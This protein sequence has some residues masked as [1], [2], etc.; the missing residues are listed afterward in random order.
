M[1]FEKFKDVGQGPT[2]A[3]GA[4]ALAAALEDLGLVENIPAVL[5]T[6]DLLEGYNKPSRQAYA[7]RIYQVTGNLMLTDEI[8]LYQVDAPARH[9]SPPS[10]LTSMAHRC[11]IDTSNIRTFYNEA[12]KEHFSRLELVSKNPSLPNLFA[13]EFELISRQSISVMED[14]YSKFPDKGQVHL[15]GVNNNRH[16][17][18]I[19]YD[20]CYDSACGSVSFYNRVGQLPLTTTF[21]TELQ[22]YQFSGWWISLQRN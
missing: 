12:A 7:Q 8:A 18:A 22:E 19:N 1:S 20:T 9:Q 11:G 10:A 21:R 15:L 3:C 16:W 14:K 2:N 17:I 6:E 4:F 5:N 13:A